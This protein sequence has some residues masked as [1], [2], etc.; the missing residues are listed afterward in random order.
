M[1]CRVDVGVGGAVACAIQVCRR[2]GGQNIFRSA[3]RIR[4]R[5]L[6][7]TCVVV[8]LVAAEAGLLAGLE[9]TMVTRRATVVVFAD[10]AGVALKT[11]V[12]RAGSDTG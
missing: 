5:A 11:G 1:V 2:V 7:E 10:Y 8:G 12:V 6:R 3:W 4:R 9:R